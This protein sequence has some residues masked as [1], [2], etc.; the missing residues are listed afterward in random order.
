[1][2]TCMVSNTCRSKPG[3]RF[4]RGL[5]HIT[6]LFT[7]LLM[8]L[9]LVACASE[10][11]ET[12]AIADYGSYGKDLALELAQTWPNRSPG[13]IQEQAAGDFLI[14]AFEDL[15]Y[16]PET[17][18]FDFTDAAGQTRS[19]RNIIVTIKGTGFT[20]ADEETG[21]TT[22][23][24]RQVI[25][26][27]HYDVF[28][29]AEEAD[30]VRATLASEAA[31]AAATATSETTT[32][33]TESSGEAGTAT[34]AETEEIVAVP[35]LADFDGI[36]DNA[37]GVAALMTLAKQLKGEKL[38]YDVILIAFGAGEANYA[39]SGYYAGQMTADALAR[40]D[41]MYNMDGIYAGDKV[42]A[43][44]G[45]N[46]VLPG[47]QKDYSRRR[48]LYEATD[49]FYDYELYTNN[50]FS[51]YTNQASFD[52]PWQND[53]QTAVYREWTQRESDHTPFD[54]LNIPIVFFETFDYDAKTLDAMKESNNPAFAATN[55][56]I[57]RTVFDSSDYL[58]YIFRQS[59]ATVTN[60]ASGSNT[61]ID[62]QLTRR[63]NNIAFILFEALHKPPENAVGK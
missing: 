46:S 28:F 23:L 62:D 7:A 13:S 1:M 38:G 35:T 10:Q 12:A 36:Q 15:G 39:G 50:R 24:E 3:S 47:Y 56:A 27:A 4:V 21:K 61:V 19:S 57:R 22:D 20:S 53:S 30:A 54:K 9:P 16:K 44:A 17:Q 45:Q 34:V 59:L 49:V 29:T 58:E 55:G 48:K 52:V 8:L 14:T 31:A 43:H 63:I 41:V 5:F 26:G 51:L 40:T 18:S 60:A 33:A 2:M 37:S 11:E 32:A 6:A 25:V 42:Y